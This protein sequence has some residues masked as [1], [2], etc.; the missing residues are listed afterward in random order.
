MVED[1]EPIWRRPLSASPPEMQPKAMW[2]ARAPL[3][4]TRVGLEPLD[5]ARHAA[6]LYAAAHGDPA[7]LALWTYLPYGPFAGAGVF[8][9]WL[10][11]CAAA[12]DPVF[13]AIR[14]TETGLAQGMAAY[15]GVRPQ[16]GVV[17]IGHI[18]FGPGLKR[19]TAATEALYLLLS[20][21]LDGLRY[22]RVEWKCD[23]LNAA[24]RRAARRLGFRFEG[25]FYR[26]MIVKGRNRDT[27]WYSLL[28]EEWPA[29]RS[30]LSAW[31][32][33]DNFDADGRQRRPLGEPD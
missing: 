23:A 12:A 4:G 24:S 21:A 9:D 20:A 27:A 33:P 13:F 30:R 10:R 3:A 22:R 28:A 17:E 15:L 31:L 16:Q 1:H 19:T 5:P 11:D 2:P 26:H 6:D 7:A 14:D 8:R 25:I 29:M 32:A 18:W